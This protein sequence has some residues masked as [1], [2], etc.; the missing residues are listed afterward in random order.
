LKIEVQG[1]GAIKTATIDLKPLTILIGPNNSGKT[2]LA[3]VLLA[4]FGPT[5]WE[6]YSKAYAR[7]ELPRSFPLLDSAIEKILAESNATIDVN[8]FAKEEGEQYFQNVADFARTW[9]DSFMSSELQYFL[10]N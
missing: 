5:G 7:G 10:M 3:Y 4:L 2:W 1:L 6:H 9:L 8:K